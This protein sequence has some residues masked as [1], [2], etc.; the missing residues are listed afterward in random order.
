MVGIIPSYR[1]KWEFLSEKH[2]DLEG[3]FVG[4]LEEYSGTPSS[5]WPHWANA[6]VG[7]FGAGKTQLLYNIFKKSLQMGFLP[8][9]FIAE[10]LFGDIYRLGEENRTPGMLSEIASRKMINARDAV[11]K[12]DKEAL[13]KIL[14]P[15]HRDEIKGMV[16]DL[17]NNLDSKDVDNAK[18]IVLVDELE[19][20][21]KSL[22]DKVRADERSPL[23][24]WLERKDCLKF[25]AL[26]P[27]GIYEMGGADQTRCYR[28]VIPPVDVA[29]IKQNYFPHYPGKANACWWLS[30][31]KPRH[32][33]KAFEKLK[34]LDTGTIEAGEIQLFIRDELDSIGQDPSSVPPAIL[35]ELE[36]N[37]WRYILD[38]TPVEGEVGRRYS[39]KLD[40]LNTALFS[41]KLTELFKLKR[42][43]AVLIS[44]YFKIV[45]KALSDEEGFVYVN[46]KD[47]SELFALTLDLLLEYEHASPGVKERLGEIM[48]LYEGSKDPTLHAYL[49]PLW[50][51]RETLRELPLTIEEVRRTFPFPVMNPMVRGHVPKN[52]REKVEGQELPIWRWEEGNITILFFA[53]WRDFASYSQTDEFRDLTLPKEKGVLYIQPMGELEGEKTPFLQ[54]L[55]RNGKLNGVAT[56]PL[57][58]DFFLSLA[59][60][61]K[62]WIPERLMEKLSFLQKDE[63]D[64]ILLRKVRVYSESINQL[65][66]G[67]LPTPV[68]LWIGTPPDAETLWGKRQIGDRKVVVPSI[69]LTFVDFN[70]KERVLVAQLQELF[71][72]GREGRGVGDLHFLLPRGGKVA[73]A[74]RILHRYER[75]ELKES[76]PISRLKGYFKGWRELAIL[77]RLVPLGDFLKLEG[78]EDVNRLL[79]AFWRAIRGDFDYKELDELILWLERDVVPTIDEATSLE[80]R[81]I[82]FFGMEGI[83]CEG[84]EEVV[85]AKDSINRL[86]KGAREAVE[87]KGVGAPLIK[88]LYKLFAIELRRKESDLRTFQVQLREAKDACD[89]LKEAGSSLKKNFWEYGKAVQFV[90]LDEED[91][92]ESISEETALRGKLTLQDLRERADGG[93]NRLERI[94]SGFDDLEK[95]VEELNQNFD[96]LREG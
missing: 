29:Y 62:E 6:V 28:L 89:K 71:K 31:G 72:G 95:H 83:D 58:T 19:Q 48:K 22:Q 59:G 20:Q 84:N 43:D 11:A 65:V 21:Y 41:E 24:D 13:E 88:A 96:K 60:E 2:K 10:D 91:I 9:Y 87:D 51:I 57:L 39:I 81:A 55:E 75:G 27:A 50:E 47:L 32:V 85:R 86:L 40:K 68:S 16:E 34:D 44:Y 94:S 4:I 36:V 1:A 56:P 76:D 15:T 70:L 74:T 30:R 49:L 64:P 52:I 26:A 90:E 73:M 69:A 54:W 17:I 12:S 38:L 37:K 8:L 79:E 3:K 18:T 82:E 77:A 61:I 25:V 23:R 5:K 33:F 63:E 35:E 80:V 53:S 93:R 67:S 78:E 45:I 7:V 46:P 92:E 66:K 14:N 42:E